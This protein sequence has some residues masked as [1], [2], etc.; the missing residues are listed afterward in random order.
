MAG[1]SH[2]NRTEDTPFAHPTSDGGRASCRP[3]SQPATRSGRLGRQL[4]RATIGFWSGGVLLGTGGCILGGLMPYHLPIARA[5]SVLWWGAYLGCFGA[6][7]GA[8]FG[9]LSDRTPAGR[10]G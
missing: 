3:S 10:A 7:I 8:L 5:I 6:S 9:L 4:G 1:T 2:A